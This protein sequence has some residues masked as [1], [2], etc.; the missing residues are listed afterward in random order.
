MPLGWCEARTPVC[1]GRAYIRHHR[2]RRSQGGSDG[3]ANLLYAC[4]PCHVYIHDNPAISYER[5]WMV[6]SWDAVS[7]VEDTKPL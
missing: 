1:T 3:R 7:S 2:K 5:G 4:A 6:R